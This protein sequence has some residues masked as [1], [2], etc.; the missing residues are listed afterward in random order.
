MLDRDTGEE[1]LDGEGISKAMRVSPWNVCQLKKLTKSR[2]PTPNRAVQL[3][4]AAPEEILLIH[5]RSC[6]E[7]GHDELRQY[8]VGLSC[9]LGRLG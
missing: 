1:E 6:F 8:G 2:L 3:P 7:C 4:N 9:D 5:F